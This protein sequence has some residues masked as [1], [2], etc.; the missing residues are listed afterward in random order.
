[1]NRIFAI[2]SPVTAAVAAATAGPGRVATRSP[3]RSAPGLNPV[4][5]MAGTGLTA[6]SAAANR[7]A[8]SAK[9]APGPIIAVIARIRAWSWLCREYATLTGATGTPAVI[10]PSVTSRWSTPLPDSTSSGRPGPRPRS[11]RAWPMASAA[12]TASP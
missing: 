1:M 12:A 8:S 6:S 5:T 3:T 7:P 10:A 4:A 9:T 2:E 11:S